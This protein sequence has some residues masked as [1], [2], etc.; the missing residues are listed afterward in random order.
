[1]KLT[2]KQRKFLEMVMKLHESPETS[3][4]SDYPTTTRHALLTGSYGDIAA[5]NLNDLAARYKE[6]K[7]INH[8]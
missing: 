8:K 2:D 3:F 5:S 1:M 4:R 7:R 6:W